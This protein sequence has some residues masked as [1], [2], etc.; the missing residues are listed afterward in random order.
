[1]W[2][3]QVSNIVRFDIRGCHHH[4]HNRILR[5]ILV[6][7]NNG[8]PR[9]FENFYHDI[10]MVKMF[11]HSHHAESGIGKN[12]L[13]FSLFSAVTMLAGFPPE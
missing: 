1:V 10:R 9:H 4:I 11:R 6:S 3:D 2:N 12:F 13:P 5:T 8:K 7:G